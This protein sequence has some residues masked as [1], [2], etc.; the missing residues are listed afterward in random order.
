MLLTAHCD[1]EV[2]QALAQYLADVQDRFNTELISDLPCVNELVVHVERF[3]GK[4]LRPTLVLLSS[5]AVVG[6]T[7]LQDL[8][9]PAVV[10]AAVCEMVHMATLVHDDILDSA[11][12][13]R[14][15]A[16]INHL[17]GNETAVMLGDYLISHAYH[18]CSSLGRA[19]ISRAIARA[20]NVVCEGEL[21][22]LSNRENWELDERTYYEIIR[23]KTAALVG[24]CCEL[25]TLLGHEP[26]RR[27]GDERVGRALFA[28]G[29]KLGIAFQIIDDL[30]DLSGDEATVGKSL[31]RDLA[32]GK[33][34]LPVIRYLDQA[35]PA[36]AKAMRDLLR[37][38]AAS[39]DDA[40]PDDAVYTRICGLLSDAGAL[41]Q[42]RAQAETLVAE[43]R[44][45]LSDCLAPSP[46]RE[47]MLAMAQQVTR[48]RF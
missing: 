39:G 27:N 44:R 48:R 17:R 13:R 45:D 10:T 28:F 35:D 19:D 22:Q 46:A 30:L 40:A 16:T 24:L 29:E 15:G 3:R 36:K 7:E 25:P 5:M 23:R 18:L 34:T 4:M 43:A 47:T 41:E 21:L 12:M 9:E 11:E 20:T 14:S 26:G 8:H 37:Q 33:L 32:K 38:G 2:G 42:A 6:R 31:G 1:E